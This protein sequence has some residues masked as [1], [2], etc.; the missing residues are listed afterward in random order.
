MIIVNLDLVIPAVILQEMINIKSLNNYQN[1]SKAYLSTMTITVDQ[2]MNYAMKMRAW[3]LD[4]VIVNFDRNDVINYLQH[5]ADLFEQINHSSAYLIK[6]LETDNC[7]M[8]NCVLSLIK[9]LSSKINYPI[10]V[11]KTVGLS[12]GIDNDEPNKCHHNFDNMV[13]K[14][15]PSTGRDRW[16]YPW[17]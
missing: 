11:L 15:D 10:K 1:N 14:T 7:D 5:N 8:E 13:W 16:Y 9:N 12:K 2:V 4:R 17:E 6:F 3:D